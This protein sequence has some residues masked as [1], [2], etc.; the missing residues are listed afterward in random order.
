MISSP[1]ASIAPLFPLK[2]WRRL[3]IEQL[4]HGGAS[5]LAEAGE[6]AGLPALR[7]AIATH[8]AATRGLPPIRA[9]SS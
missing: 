7:S 8:L 2:L 1:E 4:A 3:L 5:G 9:A 6:P